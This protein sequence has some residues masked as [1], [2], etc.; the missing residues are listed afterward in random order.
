M[1]ACLTEGEAAALFRSICAGFSCERC[2]DDQLEAGR[3]TNQSK[4]RTRVSYGKEDGLRHA[5]WQNGMSNFCRARTVY[6]LM[7]VA[8]R[9]GPTTTGCS[10][11]NPRDS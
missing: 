7:P 3:E 6:I 1:L 11:G 5:H 8:Q 10:N 2:A 4:P 9:Y